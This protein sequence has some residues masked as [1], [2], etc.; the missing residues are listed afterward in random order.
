MLELLCRITFFIAYWTCSEG[1]MDLEYGLVE[2][3][4]GSP[5][6]EIVFTF[7]TELAAYLVVVDGTLVLTVPNFIK[8]YPG[9]YQLPLLDASPA[10]V[11]LTALCK[12]VYEKT[13]NLNVS[14]PVE[15]PWVLLYPRNDVKLNVKNT[16]IC[17]VTGF[18]PPPVK[19]SW[20]KNN[21]NVTDGSTTS[22][23][24]PNNDRNLNVFSQLSFIPEVGDIFSCSVEH[25]ALQQPQTRIWDV[26]VKQPSIGPSVFCGVGLSLGLLSFAAGIFFIAKAKKWI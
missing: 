18:F 5:D 23:Y 7:N 1:Q 20:T 21:V 3:C 2:S 10:S 13:L 6:D 16:L 12:V 25:K 4:T 19:V 14:E 24:Y 8:D 9:F 15:P 22:R 11:G 26:E 17:H